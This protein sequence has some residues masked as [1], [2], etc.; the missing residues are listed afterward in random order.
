MELFN[1]LADYFISTGNMWAILFV[2]SFIFMIITNARRE[3]ERR[4]ELKEFRNKLDE[5]LNKL[6]LNSDLIL[7][8]WKL[9]I[10]RELKRRK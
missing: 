1:K 5:D 6:K 10:E 4:S 3:N 8:T 2:F 9:M 7:Q